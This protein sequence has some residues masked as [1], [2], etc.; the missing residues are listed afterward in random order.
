MPQEPK[1]FKRGDKLYKVP[2]AE[3]N[4]FMKEVPDAI[5]INMYEKDG[6]KYTVPMDE[7]DQFMQEVPGATLIG[8]S[9][10]KVSTP[11]AGTDL[12]KPGR[13]SMGLSP[14]PASVGESIINGE[15]EKDPVLV[16][17]AEKSPWLAAP[18]NFLTGA[19]RGTGSHIMKPLDGA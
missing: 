8:G 6:K 19:V 15:P 5:E 1:I 13:S 7:L 11:A 16:A 17:A 10:K 12:T 14:L 18:I 3:V 4:D 9:K 2:T